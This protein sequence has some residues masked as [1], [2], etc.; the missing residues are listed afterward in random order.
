MLRVAALLVVGAVVLPAC[1]DDAGQ[2]VVA[3]HDTDEGVALAALYVELLEGNGI[4]AETGPRRGS[5]EDLLAAL[6]EGEANA[7]PEYSGAGLDALAGPGSARPSVDETASALRQ[8]V[9]ARGAQVFDPSGASAQLVLVTTYETWDRT[10]VYEVS[11]L[12]ALDEDVTL[13]VPPGCGSAPGC[14]PGLR[15][16]YGLDPAEVVEVDGVA[17]RLS[18]LHRGEVLAAVVPA[19]AGELSGT[20]DVVLV[21]DRQQQPAQNVLPVVEDQDDERRERTYRAFDRLS[22]ELTTQDVRELNRRVAGGE[23]AEDVA[24]DLLEDKAVVDG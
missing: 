8:E 19:T 16:E 5:T 15:E 17:D 6:R 10:G 20:L 9:E 24:K 7:Y 21:D 18:A 14:L 22:E 13:A 12:A 23:D 3:A 2:F 4:D 1:G 11:G